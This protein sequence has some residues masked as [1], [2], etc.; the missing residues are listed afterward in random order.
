MAKKIDMLQ[1]GL[2]SKMYYLSFKQPM[3][4]Y[5]MS[6]KI[7]NNK[8]QPQKLYIWRDQLKSKGYI[9][10]K[11]GKWVSSVKPLVDAIE[12]RKKNNFS[13]EQ[14]EIISCFL[15]KMFR[16]YISQLDINFDNDFNAI[17]ILLIHFDLILAQYSQNLK[18]HPK[19]PYPKT[20][21]DAIKCNRGIY[22]NPQLRN[23]IIRASNKLGI[24]MRFAKSFPICFLTV[25]LINSLKGCSSVG[26]LFEKFSETLTYQNK[27][28]GTLEETRKPRK[29][30]RR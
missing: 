14:K 18:N 25:D 7:Y 23:N 9:L 8:V 13:D 19:I 27:L 28:I 20:I 11:E 24:P 10:Q 16:Y 22:E 26:L 17:E 15:D 30:F 21:S 3:S 4:V 6:K 12:Q 29:G 5:E 2:P 1:S